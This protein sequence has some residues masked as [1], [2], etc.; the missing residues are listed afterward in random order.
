[1]WL[2][3]SLKSVCSL[4]R[5]P[6][7][8]SA[9]VQEL[10]ELISFGITRYDRLILNG[11]FNIHVNK[12][13]DPKAVEL[14]NL[15]DSFELTQHV[16]EATHQHGNTLDLVITKGLNID[17][18]SILESPISDHHCVFF[19]ANLIVSKIKRE[20]W[21]QKRFLDEKAEAEFSNIMKSLE[22]YNLDCSWWISLLITCHLL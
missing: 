4:Y 15:L 19:D 5:P 7:Y 17:N 11:D 8:F 20:L 22:P 16:S 10:S 21:V 13:N 12:K 18:V 14:V 9:F 2:N 6:R 3:T 1:M